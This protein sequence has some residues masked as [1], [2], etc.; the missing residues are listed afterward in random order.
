MPAP[1]PLDPER[2]VIGITVATRAPIKLFTDKNEMVYFIKVDE[3]GDLYNQ[4]KFIRSNY[5]TGG[6]VYLINAKPGRYAAVACYEK[7]KSQL[8]VGEY[9]TLFPKELI[10]L[11]E[12]LVAPGKI[13]FMGDYVVDQSVGL[14][15]ADSSQRHYCQVIE[16]G[17]NVDVLTMT[18]MPVL[19]GHG[20]Y[21]YK[22]TL[23]EKH[24]DTDAE[25]RFLT[26]A[27]KHFQ[28]TGW[29]DI[30]QQRMKALPE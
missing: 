28:G 1:Q 22:G 9:T 13:A 29:A 21:F 7:K 30:I 6:Q 14:K 4:G 12:V 10:K 20:N 11:T 5:T 2:S 3:G 24:C 27:L 8:M 26:N 17:A 16:P 19:T 18:L 23:H 15:G 25:I